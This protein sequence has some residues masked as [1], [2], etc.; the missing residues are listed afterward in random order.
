MVQWGSMLTFGDCCCYLWISSM[1]RML[2][3]RKHRRRIS[4][5]SLRRHAGIDRESLLAFVELDSW[6]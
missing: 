4:D 2:V 1:G 5:F 6:K 3:K